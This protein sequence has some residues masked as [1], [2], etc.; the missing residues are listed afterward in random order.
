MRASLKQ[1][2]VSGFFGL[3][4]LQTV[5][6]ME[7]VT[8]GGFETG[9]LNG[10]SVVNLGDGGC[11]TNAWTVNSIGGHGCSNNVGN[12]TAPTNGTFA[13]YNTFDGPAGT[14]QISQQ[15]TLPKSLASATL[16]FFDTV[17][18]VWPIS[19]PRIFSIDLYDATNTTL[20]YNLYSQ[21]FHNVDQEW[22]SHI[23]DVTNGL[24]DNAD[25]T[26]TLRV[27][28]FIP[29]NFT[30]PAGFGIDDISLNIT[31]SEVPEPGSLALVGVALA[32]LAASRRK[33]K[34]QA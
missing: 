30:G 25:Q 2:L 5:S 24:L 26:V 11:G 16:S 29:E 7:V 18:I 3:A 9:S 1:A 28:N 15:L 19:S 14:L 21:S 13:V 12:M 6:A 10:W 27:S 33:Q 32:G 22:V 4:C 23:V 17:R 31:S 8:N 34:S 20:L